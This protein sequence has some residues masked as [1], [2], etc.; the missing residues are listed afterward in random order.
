MSA[1]VKAHRGLKEFSTSLLI[2]LTDNYVFSTR[3]MDN[4]YTKKLNEN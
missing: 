3:K 4:F 2:F 1:F